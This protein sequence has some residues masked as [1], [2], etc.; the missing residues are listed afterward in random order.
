MHSNNIG[1]PALALE[2]VYF[3]YD[4]GIRY[5]N[6]S[7]VVMPTPQSGIPPEANRHATFALFS[8]SDDAAELVQDCR[9]RGRRLEQI[10]SPAAAGKITPIPGP[11]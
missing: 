2:V 1:L 8:F 3:R 9:N 7:R 4:T 11:R 6:P 5:L 10:A